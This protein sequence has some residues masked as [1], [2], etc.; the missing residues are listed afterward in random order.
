MTINTLKQRPELYQ[1]TIELI[2]KSFHYDQSH[3]FKVDF[4]PLMTEENFEN[5]F[6]K[7]NEENK[8]IAHIAC[9]KKYFNNHPVIMLGGIAVDPQ[10]RGEGHFQ[11]LM[12]HVLL[13]KKDEASLFLLWSDQEKL[14]RKF[15]F[16]LCGQQFEHEKN[17][18]TRND[19]IKTKYSKLEDKEKDEIHSLFKNSFEKKYLTFK[20]E[21]KDWK[22][23]EQ[24]N[25]TDLFIR[26]KESVIND[27]FFMNKGQDLSGIIFEYGTESEIASF[28]KEI[29]SYGRVWSAFPLDESDPLQFQFMACP[30]DKKLFSDFIS[31]LSLGRIKFHDIN[32]IKQEIYFNFGEDLLALEIEELLKGLLGPG[33]FEELPDIQKIFISG[34]DSV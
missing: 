19:F 7:I 18:A 3:S 13:E 30:G 31:D 17:S 27:Y 26:K 11:E 2:E 4:A 32:T 29:S 34:L 5:I 1:S 6:F 14:Y 21:L 8:V 25:S 9:K 33:I 20:R 22:I 12:S 10:M 23:I 28:L 24:M 15:G 16:Y